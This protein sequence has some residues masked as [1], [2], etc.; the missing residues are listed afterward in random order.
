[1][2]AICPYQLKSFVSEEE[3]A[4][5]FERCLPSA[6]MSCGVRRVARVGGEWV[7]VDLP[8]DRI[9]ITGDIIVNGSPDGS[10]DEP[11]ARGGAG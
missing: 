8:R 2:V 5:A 11:Q 1:L 7:L 10:P 6:P 4:L 3:F 9:L